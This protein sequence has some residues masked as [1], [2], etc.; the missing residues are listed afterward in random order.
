ME[1]TDHYE[2][3]GV[4]PDASEAKIKKAYKKMVIMYHPDKVANLGPKLKEVAN[5]EMKKINIAKDVLLNDD[6]R[7]AYDATLKQSAA[8]A[9]VPK[10]QAR[11][12]EGEEIV[13]FN[14]VLLEAR[15][16]IDDLRKI[17]GDVRESENFFIQAKYAANNNDIPR[18]LEFAQHSKEAAKSLLYKYS[19]N[20]LLL[21][22]E[23]LVKHRDR[24]VNIGEAFEKFL[25]ARNSMM[26]NDFLGAVEVSLDAVN[27]ANDIA[28]KF[29]KAA[30]ERKAAKPPSP[31]IRR[32]E[33]KA[34]QQKIPKGYVA[35]W[36][37][38]SRTKDLEVYE[39]ALVKVW[40]DG[41][42]TEEEQEEL[43]R[44][45]EQ[46]GVGSE[47]H[48]RMEKEVR[49]R[50]RGNVRLYMDAMMRVLDDGIIDEMEREELARLRKELKLENNSEFSI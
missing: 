46:L 38:E 17:D 31:R 10:Q 34:G 35:T 9:P 8:A 48:E 39:D 27:I 16:Y 20:V 37:E 15:K 43:D 12:P 7:S 1:D 13:K 3:L 42:V 45:K 49:E 21:S 26:R 23:K 40:A 33:K 41:V 50:R 36:D 44:L 47:E 24:G 4:S 14:T 19:V 28:R 2:L 6:E 25:E 32:V 11:G 18:A 22:K 29:R 30:E 5:E